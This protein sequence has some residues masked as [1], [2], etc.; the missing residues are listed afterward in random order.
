MPRLTVLMG[1]PGSGKSTYAS[2]LGTVVTT[3]ASRGNPHLAGDVL[4]D[5]YR[6]INQHLAAGRD[7]VF[8]TTGANPAVRKAAVTIAKRYGAQINAC[9]LDTPLNTCLEAQRGRA[10]PVAQADVRRIHDSVRG[11]IAGL[12]GE[13]F[14]NVRITRD[15][16]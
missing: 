4:H 7:V 10:K 8:D 13:G 16:K 14:Q 6:Q 5:A 11:Q 15:R 9:V 1:A 12:K 2:R 3:D